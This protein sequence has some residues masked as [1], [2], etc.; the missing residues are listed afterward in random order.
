[1]MINL[2]YKGKLLFHKDSFILGFIKI[3]K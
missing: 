1:L 2:A 3:I